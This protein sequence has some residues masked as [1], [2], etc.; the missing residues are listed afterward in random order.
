MYFVTA[1]MEYLGRWLLMFTD[2]VTI[3][4]PESLATLMK[5]LTEELRLH[6]LPVEQ[7]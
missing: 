7:H 5:N 2:H 3:E 6:Y 1:H 4:S